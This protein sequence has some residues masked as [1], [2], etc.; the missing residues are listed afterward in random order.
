[1]TAQPLLASHFSVSFRHI[2]RLLLACIILSGHQA[3][4]NAAENDKTNLE[5]EIKVT[6]VDLSTDPNTGAASIRFHVAAEPGTRFYVQYDRRG[7]PEF[8]GTYFVWE[9]G[10]DDGAQ[11]E[12]KFD[13]PIGFAGDRYSAAC[14]RER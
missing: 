11:V 4:L 6:N 3:S 9:I 10:A 2:R 7:Q 12:V 1:M 13:Y 5:P 14:W 8:A